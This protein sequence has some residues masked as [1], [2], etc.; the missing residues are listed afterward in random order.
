MF[1][2]SQ[3]LFLGGALLLNEKPRGKPQLSHSF[4]GGVPFFGCAFTG[5][6]KEIHNFAAGGG[7]LFSGLFGHAHLG[8]LLL[9]LFFPEARGNQQETSHLRAPFLGKLESNAS[10]T[11]TPGLS[12]DTSCSSAILHERLIC[13]WCCCWLKRR[14]P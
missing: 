13:V 6:P 9:L 11:G 5:N 3:S 14:T 10:G 12:S 4:P 7:V 2:W 8:V 1:Y